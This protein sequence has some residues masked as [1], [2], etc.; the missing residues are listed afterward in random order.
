MLI[1][2]G[3]VERQIIVTYG[4]RPKFILRRRGGGLGAAA[5]TAYGSGLASNLLPLGF[6]QRSF[7]S[8]SEIIS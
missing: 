8:H 2:Y 7:L 6:R 1:A 5:R 4:A 3:I